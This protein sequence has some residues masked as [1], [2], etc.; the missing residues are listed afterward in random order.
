MPHLL[1]HKT[2]STS[3]K[4]S[5]NRKKISY[6]RSSQKK[7]NEKLA[8]KARVKKHKK[9]FFRAN[10]EKRAKQEQCK[11]DNTENKT[12]S[13][14]N[15]YVTQNNVE[16]FFTNQGM[17]KKIGKKAREFGFVKHENKF[18]PAKF[19]Q[20]I[21][22][23]VGS[24]GEPESLS[25]INELFNMKYG[26]KMQNKPFW[27]RLSSAPC[28]DLM[29]YTMEQAKE[30]HNV[31]S[32]RC[33]YSEGEELIG[34]INRHGLDVEDIEVYD[35]TYWKLKSELSDEYPG[36]RTILK[37]EKVNN[38]YTEAGDEVYDEVGNSGIGLQTIM[39]LKTGSL[40]KVAVTAETAN[41]KEFVSVSKEHRILALMDNGYFKLKLLEHI[42]E[43]GSY[44]ITKGRKNCAAVISDCKIWGTQQ[45]GNPLAEEYNGIK[46]SDALTKLRKYKQNI[47]FIGTFKEELAVR[48]VAFYSKDKNDV[49]LLVTNIKNNILSAKLITDI[50]RVRWQTELLYK[51]LK[52]GNSLRFSKHTSNKNILMVL[53]MA[54]LCAFFLKNLVAN[55]LSQMLKDISF[56]KIHVGS[57]WFNDYIGALFKW[58]F[59]QIRTMLREML[60]KFTFFTKSKQS[61]KKNLEHRTIRSILDDIALSYMASTFEDCELLD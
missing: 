35:G 16:N 26:G 21:L 36:A 45:N 22:V 52:S 50:Y 41:E 60:K 61:K 59:E 29:G 31:A 27:N 49:V 20:S 54:S 23:A 56:F 28:V 40:I 30:S 39:S 32:E 8:K 15:Q 57:S 37:K 9:N 5:S 44:F 58:D 43:E 6:N 3:S 17:S 7:E 2:S 19:I 11:F 4:K 47:E 55:F 12:G 53:I 1:S 51:N 34:C 46:V 18:A 13:K 14:R 42:M 33:P 38:T 25:K 10:N 48:M 24:G